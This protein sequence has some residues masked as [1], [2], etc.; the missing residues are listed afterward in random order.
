M[1]RGVGNPRPG[2]MAIVVNKSQQVYQPAMSPKAGY[3][4]IM[5][6]NAGA[7]GLGSWGI[8]YTPPLGN[9]IWLLEVRACVQIDTG[10]EVER[11]HFSLHKGGAIPQNVNIVR[12]WSK[13]IDF[14]TYMGLDCMVV[15]GQFRQFAWTIERKYWGEECRFAVAF[16]NASSNTGVIYVFFKISEG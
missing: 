1:L 4:R 14:P 13:I 10:G 2:R 6:V 3:S 16:Y 9:G 12:S 5:A 8:G 15:L 7:A 11:S